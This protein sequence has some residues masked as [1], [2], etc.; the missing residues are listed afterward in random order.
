MVLDEQS[1]E[2]KRP[3]LQGTIPTRKRSK[4]SHYSDKITLLSGPKTPTSSLHPQRTPASTV[5]PPE[6]Q[7]ELSSF[8]SK[9]LP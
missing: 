1:E 3:P 9:N 2:M 8:S 7:A 5:S 6:S 4:V